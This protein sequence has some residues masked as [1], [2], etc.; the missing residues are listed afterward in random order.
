MRKTD[1]L[2]I[3]GSNNYRRLFISGVISNLSWKVSG[4]R[5]ELV[6]HVDTAV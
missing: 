6:T 4:N 1:Q 5:K 2:T 3:Y